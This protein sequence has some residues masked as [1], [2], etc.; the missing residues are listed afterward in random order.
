M[1]AGRTLL[2][3]Y[4]LQVHKEFPLEQA[5]R[6]APYLQ[7]LGVSH[8]YSS[9]QLRARSGS[10]HGYD[11]VDPLM[12]NPEIGGEDDRRALVDALHAAGLGM[13]LDI[14]PNHMGVGKE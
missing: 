14:V 3:T 6:I 13:V 2:A 11:V 12:L 5:R 7:R 4:R 9:P 1:T 8:I 10:T